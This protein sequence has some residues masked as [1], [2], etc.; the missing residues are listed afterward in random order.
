MRWSAGMPTT[1]AI[2]MNH[3]SALRVGTR[4]NAMLVD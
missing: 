4:K 3:E 1:Y 2:E